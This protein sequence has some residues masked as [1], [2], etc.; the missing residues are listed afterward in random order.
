M[1]LNRSVQS[2]NTPSAIGSG[3]S[4]V[5]SQKVREINEG[6]I[7]IDNFKDFKKKSLDNV[8]GTDRSQ[9]VSATAM[10]KEEM[11]EEELNAGPKMPLTQ[12]HVG[13]KAATDSH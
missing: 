6:N 2:G 5:S 13:N 7:Q 12:K 3:H 11:V 9:R 4:K 10:I 8:T 1:P